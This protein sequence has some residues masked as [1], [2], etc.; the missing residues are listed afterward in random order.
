M[1]IPKQFKKYVNGAQRKRL[2]EKRSFVK[3]YNKYPIIKSEIT[4]ST[5]ERETR[6]HIPV[7]SDDLTYNTHNNRNYSITYQECASIEECHCYIDY[8]PSLI[9]KTALRKKA[10]RSCN[11]IP[12][13]LKKLR[14]FDYSLEQ[15]AS[16]SRV[17]IMCSHYGSNMKVTH[18]SVSKKGRT[19]FLL[20]SDQQ[21][22][23]IKTIFNINNATVEDIDFTIN[24]LGTFN[25]DIRNN[26]DL[27]SEYDHRHIHIF[28]NLKKDIISFL[29]NIRN[30]AI[31]KFAC[32]NEIKE[33]YRRDL[34]IP[35]GFKI[36]K[37]SKIG[38]GGRTIISDDK[39]TMEIAFNDSIDDFD[40]SFFGEVT[41]KVEGKTGHYSLGHRG[42]DQ[43]FTYSDNQP[44][45]LAEVIHEQEARV[46]EKR[47]NIMRSISVTLLG[48]TWHV[49]PENIEAI[50]KELKAGKTHS[51]IPSGMGI[52]VTIA[53]NTKKLSGYDIKYC[54]DEIK[55]IFGLPVYATT[56]EYD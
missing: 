2:H 11:R 7:K 31:E 43:A 17:D 38:E 27:I 29:K 26:K 23:I 24:N 32:L 52:G 35:K 37:T 10:S 39:E 25:K 6:F 49:I 41:Y 28:I 20:S 56:F 4:Y 44:I 14:M 51:F 19:T 45:T 48:H 1:S 47:R 16:T 53:D 12:P 5:D 55:E 8:L 50:K 36:V 21:M 34:T 3:V 15:L 9:K 40:M 30:S 18:E 54:G 22:R 42:I 33:K 46:L 13:Y